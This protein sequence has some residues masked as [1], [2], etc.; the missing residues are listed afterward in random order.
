MLHHF[1]DFNTYADIAGLRGIKFEQA[2]AYLK[3]NRKTIQNGVWIQ[4]FDADLIATSQHLYFAVLN[5]LMAFQNHTNL[6]KSLAM[7][8]MLYASAKRQIQRALEL[9][10]ITPQT[11]N[12]AV[13]IIGEKAEAIQAMLKETTTCLHAKLDD[14]VLE[15]S[16][17]KLGKIRQAFEISNPMLEATAKQQSTDLA[18]VE[19]VIEKM[20]L[21]A[22]QI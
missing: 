3:S 15:I 13:V 17:K 6:S 20:A 7:E 5:A 1:K 2:E 14:S 9:L 4:F 11:Q 16:P 21:L 18:V 12:L 22:T 19:L 8:T 10:G